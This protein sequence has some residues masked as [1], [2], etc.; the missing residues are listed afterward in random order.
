MT[1]AASAS[2][3]AACC[4]LRKLVTHHVREDDHIRYNDRHER[5]IRRADW[6]NGECEHDRKNE[7]RRCLARTSQITRLTTAGDQSRESP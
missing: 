4:V 3:N 5:R 6:P 1:I 7:V 2:R